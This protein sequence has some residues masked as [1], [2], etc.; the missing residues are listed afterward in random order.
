MD[1]ELQKQLVEKQKALREL[2]FSATGGK[3]ADVKAARN[4]RKEIAKILTTL[5]AK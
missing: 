1:L 5:H 4:L 3:S 2:R